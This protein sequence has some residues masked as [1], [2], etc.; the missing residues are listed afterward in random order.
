ML[1]LFIEHLQPFIDL[2]DLGE[3]ILRRHGPFLGILPYRFA[4]RP[5]RRGA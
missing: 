4:T 5:A 3:R 2:A 1:K